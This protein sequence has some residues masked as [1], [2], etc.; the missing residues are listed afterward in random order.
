MRV[1]IPFRKEKVELIIP[2]KN[3]LDI[4]SG[5][6][7]SSGF[8]EDIFEKWMADYRGYVCLS[9]RLKKKFVLG[10]RKAVAI[11]RLLTK[12]G[13]LLYSDFSRE[14]TEKMGFKKIEDIQ[15]YLNNRITQ[16][17]KI[18]ITIVPT[19]RFVRIKNNS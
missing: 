2:D 7:K 10:G 14:E 19:G 16:N 5:E 9:E 4:I 3:I 12:A 8:G 1:E 6:S 13:I 17:S 18:K 11:S 15:E